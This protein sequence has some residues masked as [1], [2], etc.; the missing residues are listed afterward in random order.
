MAAAR[1]VFHLQPCGEGSTPLLPPGTER[2][3][4]PRLR[5]RLLFPSRQEAALPAASQPARR[6]SRTGS[7]RLSRPPS[8]CF[9]RWLARVEG[10][11]RAG[12][13]RPLFI[14]ACL[15]ACLPIF[16][17]KGRGGGGGALLCLAIVRKRT[18]AV[19]AAGGCS[20][21]PLPGI[22]RKTPPPDGRTDRRRGVLAARPGRPRA[23]G[24]FGGTKVCLFVSFLKTKKTKVKRAEGPPFWRAGAPL[25]LARLH[26]TQHAHTFTLQPKA[27]EEGGSPAGHCTKNLFKKK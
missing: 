6:A 27:A 26:N 14:V 8:S 10:G 1:R 16:F 18:L 13:R 25:N 20:A 7:A 11:G 22:R 19:L 5:P 24:S 23:A 17:G 2:S 4:R 15:L 9:R 3:P 21:R 12:G